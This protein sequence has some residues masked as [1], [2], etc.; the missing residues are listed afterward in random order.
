MTNILHTTGH[1]IRFP[2]IIRAEN[3]RL[4]DSEGREYLDM[5]SGVW[6][7]SVGHSRK[8]VTE[9]IS[10]F[11]GDLMH[12]G[13]SYRHPV[14]DQTG[15]TIL[16]VTGQTN[17]KCLF[18]N[19]GSEAVE[20]SAKIISD[21]SKKPYI[22]T[23]S[24]SFLGSYGIVGSKD[25]EKWIQ[26]DWL[27]DQDVERIPFDQIAGF[28]LEPGS[29]SGQVRFPPRELIR[30]IAERV[31][32]N[33]GLIAINEITTG[34]GRTGK[35]FG[36]QHYELEPD[37]IAMGKGLGNGYPVSCVSLSKDVSERLENCHFYYNQS[38]LNSP[39]GV[40][41]AQTVIQVIRKHQLVQRS[42]ELGKLFKL[43]FLD[44]QHKYG[45]IQAVRG[46]GLMMAV[47]FITVPDFSIA[48]EISNELFK[49]RIILVKRK[50]Q[51]TI[52]LDPAL[53]ITKED[54]DFFFREFETA[55]KRISDKTPS[56]SGE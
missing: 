25:K 39:L 52:R 48:E 54:I 45:L 56:L 38:H 23:L 47:D 36:F 31:K 50:S 46:R 33:G 42:N 3:C 19:S 6:C 18:L 53:T 9:T 7:T 29:S 17:G 37:I 14:L 34:I 1:D 22:L 51:E 55:L 13:Y 28:I 8:E 27:N 26:F 12:T 5:E 35:W 16:E 49:N 40:A 10:E 21:L 15:G 30:V 2:K 43:R 4:Y 20:L 24:D 32:Q 44:L 11:A 41:T